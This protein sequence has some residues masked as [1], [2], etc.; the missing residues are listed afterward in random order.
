MVA[1]LWHNAWHETQ[2]PHV[3]A[4]LIALRS[5][6][7]FL[8]RLEDMGEHARTIGS[9]DAPLGLCAIDG[10][11]MDQLFV[12]PTA[13]GTEAAALL[14]ADAEDRLRAAGTITAHLDCLEENAPAIRFYEKMGW[15]SQGVQPVNLQTSAGPFRINCVVFAKRLV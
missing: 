5:G 14:L 3:P 11:H 15:T 7:D 2:A 1:R 12:A 13:R 9:P 8:R 10:N 4:S 6:P